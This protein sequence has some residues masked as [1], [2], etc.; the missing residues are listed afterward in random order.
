MG[1]EERCFSVNGRTLTYGPKEHTLDSLV[2]QITPMVSRSNNHFCCEGSWL[3][4]SA[5]QG[6]TGGCTRI[7]AA[8]DQ[9]T[10]SEQFSGLDPSILLHYGGTSLCASNLDCVW[11]CRDSD[12]TGQ[13]RFPFLVADK[14]EF[15]DIPNSCPTTVRAA[16]LEE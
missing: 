7:P 3:R 12:A 9:P 15:K 8:T 2:N 1:R 6:D 11:K 13:I 5:R 16:G 14:R 10:P 4:S